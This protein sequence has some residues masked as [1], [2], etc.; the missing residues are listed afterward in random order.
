MKNLTRLVGIIFLLC[1]N[2][3]LLQAQE[4]NS[5]VSFM[6]HLSVSVEAG[7]TGLGFE[8]ATTLHPNFMLRAGFVMLPPFSTEDAVIDNTFYF[9]SLV[10]KMPEIKTELE[11]KKLPTN[12]NEFNDKISMTD[13]FKLYNGK[14]LIDYYPIT[15]RRFHITA[16]IYFG[17]KNII[18]STGQLPSEFMEAVHVINKYLPVNA[19]FLPAILRDDMFIQYCYAEASPTGRINYSRQINPI[20]PYV[21]IGGGRAIPN[22]RIGCQFDIGVI[23]QGKQKISSEYYA[24]FGQADFLD[25]I[26]YPVISMRL[27]GKIF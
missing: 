2:T 9:N 27:V 17:G 14:I 5:R 24:E 8:V 10:D 23:F 21:G 26:V 13:K 3:N 25:W 16:G 22:K 19:Q 18:T 15:K 6:D 7:T 11:N 4:E 12:S 1:F 20:R